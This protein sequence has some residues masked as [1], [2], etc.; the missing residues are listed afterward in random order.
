M[1]TRRAKLA[2]KAGSSVVHPRTCK[3]LSRK[4]TC[5]LKEAL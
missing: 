4:P 1:L 3:R 5:K 2:E